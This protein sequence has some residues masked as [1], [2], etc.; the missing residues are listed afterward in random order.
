LTLNAVNLNHTFSN[1]SN[2]SIKSVSQ[3]QN[4]FAKV[5][6]DALGSVNDA[7]QSTNQ[8]VSE[9]ASGNSDMDLHNVM[10]AMQKSNVLLK[11]TVQ[12]RDR[13][14]EAYQEVMRMQV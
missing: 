2:Q 6:K 9:V 4:D 12:V 1:A 3:T 10:I 13:V 14:V 7:Q 8:L 11:T 5:F